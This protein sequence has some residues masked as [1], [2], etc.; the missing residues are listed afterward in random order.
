[1]KL[2]FI[3]FAFAAG[4]VVF[5]LQSASS[6]RAFGAGGSDRTGSPVSS[7]S[8]TGCHSSP[9]SFGTTTVSVQ[10]LDGATPITSYV[11]G[12]TYTV[13]TTIT[14]GSGSPGRYGSQ[15]VALLSGAGNPQAGSFGTPSTIGTRISTLNGR[16]Y[17]E[18]GNGSNTTGVFTAPWTA[19]AAGSGAVTLYGIGMAA[20]NNGGVG[21]DNV[22]SQITVSL[23]E[24]AVPTTIAYTQTSFCGDDNTSYTP[25]ITGTTGGTYTLINSTGN[26]N[27]AFNS[28]TGAITPSS[29]VA[30]GSF[31]VEYDYGTGTTTL[32]IIIT[33]EAA[34]IDYTATTL[35][36][37][38]ATIELPNLTAG[39]TAGTF[40]SS[41]VGLSINTSTGGIDPSASTVG[42][43]TITYTTSG[44]NGCTPVTATDMVSIATDDASFAYSSATFCQ[45]V[46]NPSPTITGVTG[47]T[48]SATGNPSWLNTSTGEIDMSTV[49]L[50]AQDITY[51]SNSACSG[52][53]TLTITIT[54]A[55][56]AT[57][58]YGASTSLCTGD[59]NVTPTITG[60]AGGTFIIGGAGVIN[61]S[62]GEID[63]MN[64]PA[65]TYDVIYNVTGSCPASETLSIT[66]VET[67][68]AD[69][70]YAE[71]IYCTDDADPT[72]T[73]NGTAGGTFTIS[74]NGIIDA[75]TGEIDLVGSGEGMYTVTYTTS[76]SCPDTLD[77]DVEI[78][79][80]EDAS[81]S[82]SA[83]SINDTTYVEC[84]D[85]AIVATINGT[86]GGTFS[87]T[88]AGLVIDA[89]TGAVDLT[90]S[91]FGSYSIIYETAGTCFEVD[92]ISIVYSLC[93]SV[94]QTQNLASYA[95]YPNPN[96]GQFTL[97]HK[98]QAGLANIRVM[99]L[100]G[101]LVHTQEVLF[102]ADDQ[103]T[104]D[105]MDV[106][107]G[108]YFLQVA[109]DDKIYTEKLNIIR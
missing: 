35:C 43:Y 68:D 14:A 6:G 25:T 61:A 91:Q 79:E 40:S 10:V 59:G 54:A 57:F 80:V 60:I 1:M 85:T 11:P 56:D 104:L 51:T 8:C 70:E 48:F 96:A 106:P 92:T 49:P 24:G 20:N 89:S 69:F 52:S 41:P 72:A 12:Q 94:D 26:A 90:Q 27:A 15:V 108:T 100:M 83:G 77:E 33:V 29:A 74:N 98:G 39:T 46:S 17:F 64:T 63:V 87:A 101:R 34:G 95:L 30:S 22:S 16:E 31:T 4:L 82:L 76:G 37:T 42:N 67:D 5:L 38:S 36:P 102:D 86:T 3:Y 71:S 21:G 65:G 58:N 7:G 28:T 32:D 18:H 88:P 93:A 53:S 109:K 55:G 9:G 75:S 45:S 84:T 44:A 47:G 66:I 103:L 62:T 2:R 81:F 105:L 23:S 50:G 107:A 78:I 99:D 19:P 13:Q 97:E 73:I